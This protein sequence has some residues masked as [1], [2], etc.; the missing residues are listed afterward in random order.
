MGGEPQEPVVAYQGIADGNGG[1][2]APAADL[3]LAPGREVA[4]AV[5]LP[6]RQDRHADGPQA[7]NEREKRDAL[8]VWDAFIPFDWRS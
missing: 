2:H 6:E 7:T 5:D 3:D 8:H 4:M 1:P